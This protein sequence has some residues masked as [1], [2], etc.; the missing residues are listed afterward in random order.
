MSTSPYRT[1][2]RCRNGS[3]M[4]AFP[5][6]GQ[7]ARKPFELLGD[8]A[9]SGAAGGDATPYRGAR[10]E[11]RKRLLAERGVSEHQLGER[12]MPLEGVAD[13]PADDAV[14]LAERHPAL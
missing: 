9:G 5:V 2:M 3:A 8:G 6:A 13:E 1:G 4:H 14:R 11:Q 10:L 12:H 7:R